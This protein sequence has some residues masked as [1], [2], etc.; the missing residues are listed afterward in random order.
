MFL[1][2][3]I[4]QQRKEKGLNQSELA[5]GIC[6]QA[7]MSNI[8]NKGT[9][10][11]LGTLIK[12]CQR[13]DLTLNDVVS[14]FQVASDTFD[15][16]TTAERLIAL[17]QIDAADQKLQHIGASFNEDEK[18]EN[19]QYQFLTGYLCL[20]NNDL[21]GAVFHFSFV[22]DG[23]AKTDSSYVISAHIAL[24]EIYFQRDQLDRARFY[25]NDI[26]SML[27]NFEI[28]SELTMFWLKICVRFAYHYLIKTGQNSAA[29]KLI[30][31]LKNNPDYKISSRFVAEFEKY[32]N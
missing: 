22:A 15:E 29:Q 13:L 12:L 25:F 1:N 30:D 14:E 20:L 17:D 10:P 11:S 2:S 6:T 4:R 32:S 28:T 18:L 8:E 9:V 26:K 21:D 27:D 19:K 24:G 3:I 31:Q 7:T 5:A 23:D 16:I